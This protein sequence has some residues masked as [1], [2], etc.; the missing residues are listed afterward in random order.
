MKTKIFILVILYFITISCSKKQDNL[1]VKVRMELIKSG[2]D[3]NFWKSDTLACDAFKK[4]K[5]ADIMIKQKLLKHCTKNDFIYLFGNPILVRFINDNVLLYYI[6]DGHL[7]CDNLKYKNVLKLDETA[8]FVITFN[9]QD[10]LLNMRF[11][12]P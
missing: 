2:F 6:V 8:K 1:L 11:M 5:N 9:K 10:S 12:Y 7:A 3:F 4:R